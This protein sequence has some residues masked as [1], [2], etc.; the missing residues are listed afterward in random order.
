MK[1]HG[2]ILLIFLATIG[3]G[4]MPIFTLVAYRAGT[5]AGELVLLRL[6]GAAVLMWVFLLL[7]GNFRT[8]GPKGFGRVA[9]MIG[10]PFTLTILAKFLAFT[11]MPVGV[12]QAIFYGYPLVV[13]LISTTT[14]RER[15]HLSRLFGYLIIFAGILFTLDFNDSR[16]TFAGLA[17]SF[18]STFIY[19]WYILSIRNKNVLP[20]SSVHITTIAMTTG[21]VIMLFVF[22]FMKSNGF[23]FSPSA[24]WGIAGLVLISSI[25]AFLAFNTG[26]KQVDGSLA[27][28]IC[29]FE[30]IFTIIFEIL[31]LEGFYTPRQFVGI[32]LI[33]TGII[34]SLILS[35]SPRERATLFPPMEATSETD[36]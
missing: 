30:P 12:V 1:T 32:I 18:A 6:G 10:I 28:I 20:I 4:L 3:Y 13:M 24:W 8:P 31:F 34:L 16:I 36:R 21:T 17:L 19:S 26:A 11:T 5:S 35:R 27:A 23:S 22:P 9:I 15:F 2:S 29:C 14:G 7:K 25:G 33:P